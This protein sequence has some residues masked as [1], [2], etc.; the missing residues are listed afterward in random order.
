MEQANEAALA[1][2]PDPTETVEAE[3]AAAAEPVAAAEAVAQR[4]TDESAG[5][6]PAATGTEAIDAEAPAVDVAFRR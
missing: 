2:E 3:G 4:G 1:A 5:I 6:E